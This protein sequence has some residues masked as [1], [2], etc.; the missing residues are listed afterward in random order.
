MTEKIKQD[1]QNAEEQATP[2]QDRN[3]S[4]LD[5]ND[6]LS[7][8][9]GADDSVGVFLKLVSDA[10]GNTLVQIDTNSNSDTAPVTVSTIQGT[11]YDIMSL[12]AASNDSIT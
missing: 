8:H 10:A 4:V 5:I 11:G 9:S 3:E 6:V 12:L 1:G 7:N 2:V